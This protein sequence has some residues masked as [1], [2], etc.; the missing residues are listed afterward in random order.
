MKRFCAVLVCACIAGTVFATDIQD[1][2]SRQL[3]P[4][5]VSGLIAQGTVQNTVYRKKGEIPSLVPASTLAREA[6]AFWKGDE[7]PFFI[8]TLYLY[9]KNPLK[10]GAPG[11]DTD[12]ISV[13]L[14]SLSK[15]EGL[16]YYSPSRKKMRTL[17]EKSY[18]IES[19]DSKKRLPD[20]LAGSADGVTA[21]VLQ[22]DLTF[23]EY[24]YR[25]S[26]RQTVDSVAFFSVNIDAM[27]YSF[28]KLIQPEKL[29]VSL[30]VQDLGYWL[31]V[32]N[33][34]KADFTAIPGIEGKITSSFSA[35]AEAVYKWF[36][37]EYEKQ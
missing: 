26:W 30:I 35:R 2:L 12:R 11:I 32:Y 31:L 1:F 19:V 8:E 22:K 4:A 36:I 37:T 27:S 13:I 28:L 10:Q 3:P 24:A 23:G 33:L 21:M 6:V 20:P 5:A 16:E 17:Y 18:I 14:R 25:Y 29:R 34:T 15:L 9:K 7:A